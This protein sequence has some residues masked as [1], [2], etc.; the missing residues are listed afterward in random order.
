MAAKKT[1]FWARALSLL[2]CLVLLTGLIPA[3]LAEEGDE[4]DAPDSTSVAEISI[5]PSLNLKMGENESGSVTVS[6]Q[7]GDKADS[8][9]SADITSAGDVI[10]I[11]DQQGT[12]QVTALKAGDAEITVTAA[13]G[14]KTATCQVHVDEADPEPVP[15]QSITLSPSSLELKPGETKS[16]TVTVAP[17]NADDRS[18]EANVTKGSEVI[19][20]ENKNGT[21]NVT[22]LKAG[23]GEV[24]VTAR[25][26]SGKSATCSVTVKE[27]APVAVT[28][29]TLTPTSAT[30]TVGGKQ[31][32][33]ANV[34]PANATN[35]EVT[36]KSSDSAI[37]SVDDSGL[38]TA[39]AA[40]TAS[41]VAATKDGGFTAICTVTVNAAKIPVTGVTVTPTAVSMTVSQT[42][43]LTATV[44][45]NNATDRT[46]TWAS[47]N[48]AVATVNASGLV[49][50]KS[51]GTA[52][53]TVT[54]NDGKKTASC[55]V[56]VNAGAL[57]LNS[58]SLTLTAK[59]SGSTLTATT[60]PDSA[61]SGVTWNIVGTG[62]GSI[63]SLSTN[64]GK[65]C[66]VTPLAAGTTTVRATVTIQGQTYTENCTV[67]VTSSSASDITYT[68]ARSVP[69]TFA[70]KDFSSVCDSLT[71]YAL[72]SV[73]FSLPSSSQGTLYYDYSSNGSYDRVVTASTN[74][75]RNSA[76][77]LSRVTFVPNDS[78]T[79]TVT[80]NYS[81]RDT[82]DTVYSGR[83]LIR[84]GDSTGTVT[85]STEKNTALT[86][87]DND[88]NRFSQDL[89][90]SSFQYIRFTSLP[91]SS[92]GT[93]YYDYDEDASSNRAVT[94]ATNYY[95]SKASYLDRITFVPKAN[96][97]GTVSVPFT[98]QDTE[99][100]TFN[101]TLKIYVG[102]GTADLSYRASTGQAVTFSASDFNTYCK[103]QTGSALD[104]VRFTLPSR[105]TLYYGYNSNGSY[106]KTVT[107]NTS[108]YRSSTPSLNSVSYV[109]DAS[110]P[111]TV[112]IPFTGWSTD[113]TRFSGTV[114]ITYTG[115]Q[116]VSAIRYT[117]TGTPV[118]FRAQDFT[119]ACS[120]RGT[121]SLSH[122]TFTLPNAISGR[123]YTSYTSPARHGT[124]VMPG[125]AYY[126]SS[127]PQLD[128]VTFLPKAGFSGT[129]T[130]S[131]TARDRDGGTYN[132]TVEITVAPG[133]A[134][135]TFADV[136]TGYS[137]C[138]SSVDFLYKGGVVT[139]VDATHYA[140]AQSI[141]RGDFVLMLYRAF[142]LR[143][144][145]TAS[146]TDVPAGSYY[147]EAIAAAK[148][149]GIATG[150]G[151]GTFRPADPLTRQDAMLLLQ[152]SLSASGQGIAGASTNVLSRFSD[153]SQV[154]SYAQSAVC[155]MVQ[156]GIIQGD[157]SGRLNPTQS[158]TRGEMA[159][160]LHR[161]LTL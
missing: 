14:G 31:Q 26:G 145:G 51:A 157:S 37:A 87:D 30:L 50:A 159:T 17:D 96:Y 122:V 141:S 15:V 160:I 106:E 65:S 58:R 82:Q 149:L 111:T 52:V 33:T 12:I 117:S 152:R 8:S 23:S 70:V 79:G 142:G 81:A 114:A 99:G 135:S 107:A 35:K 118:V 49:T 38:V 66:T 22:A 97:T 128:G 62:G 91:A 161:V 120:I 11:Q 134:S 75:Y 144:S 78:F 121:T 56:T 18:Y 110:T 86:L 116:S 10:R 47:N 32:L 29:V 80:V 109:P 153:R 59:G 1:F 124:E 4:P 125:A 98:G 34:A 133:T 44:A 90:G 76:P 92:R 20:I 83:V 143:A 24:T 28:G 61:A 48:A 103:E 42:L 71:G 155:S 54:T 150:G 16:F 132:G 63:V 68:T 89:T 77:Y 67:R 57:S 2:L 60:L 53:I 147:A 72:N 43:Q 19:Q 95:R 5:T 126:L 131:Y 123:L 64:Q 40:G 130:V 105:G 73:S 129:A 74:Y 36:W 115:P 21:I 93:F 113:G 46:V 104:Y 140:P 119:A 127:T 158:L 136:G 41:I 3:A 101:G 7:P 69:V 139:G 154:A 151:D 137:W 156:A 102:T 84:V 112:S 6:V 138:A 55:T 100:S 25:D 13:G 39:R 27:D 108:Y 88:F 148:A 146:F 9:Y 45:P 85:Y 94:T